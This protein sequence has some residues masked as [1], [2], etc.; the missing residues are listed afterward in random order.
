MRSITR[1][2]VDFH[3]DDTAEWSVYMAN[4]T[5]QVEALTREKYVAV[6]YSTKRYSQRSLA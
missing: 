2:D 5:S 6:A 1:S 3:D 4:L